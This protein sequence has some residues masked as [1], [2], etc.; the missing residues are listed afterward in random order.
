MTFIIAMQGGVCEAEEMYW[1][2]AVTLKRQN[3]S[4]ILL[5]SYSLFGGFFYMIHSCLYH[6]MVD[7]VIIRL[8]SGNPSS[9]IENFS[10]CSDVPVLPFMSIKLLIVLL[11]PNHIQNFKFGCST[12]SIM[13]G[14]FRSVS[15]R[16]EAT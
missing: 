14:A 12:C 6:P 3:A 13:S 16:W 2:L 15:F 9:G 8:G 5:H 11:I 4:A 7:L 10:L 1:L